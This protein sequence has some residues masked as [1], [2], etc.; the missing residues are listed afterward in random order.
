MPWEGIAFD[1]HGQNTQARGVVQQLIGGKYRVIFP[2][3]FATAEPV[4]P[5]R[6]ATPK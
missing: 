4:W 3:A 2:E 5:M 1:S 6:K